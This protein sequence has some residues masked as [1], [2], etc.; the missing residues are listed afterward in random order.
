MQL[1]GTSSFIIV[2]LTPTLLASIHRAFLDSEGLGCSPALHLAF[3]HDHLCVPPVR[4]VL[5]LVAALPSR[6]VEHLDLLA[7]LRFWLQHRSLDGVLALELLLNPLDLVQVS[8]RQEVI[9]SY[10]GTRSAA[11]MTFSQ[12]PE[13]TAKESLVHSTPQELTLRMR[14][15]RT[16]LHYYAHPSAS[17]SDH[18]SSAWRWCIQPRDLTCLHYLRVSPDHVCQFL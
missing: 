8:N 4:L 15:A 17:T 12:A 3:L 13:S 9:T 1:H 10:A 16:G 14:S 5:Q 11:S 2:H 7:Q 18:M 6:S